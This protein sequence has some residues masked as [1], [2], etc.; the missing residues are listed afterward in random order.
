L[1]TLGK[2]IAPVP[3]SPRPGE[4]ATWTWPICPANRR[5]LAGRSSPLFVRWYVSKRIFRPTDDEP[6][7]SPLTLSAICARG[8]RIVTVL[9]CG[10]GLQLT[11][12]MR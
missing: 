2:L 9:A 4:S 10:Q 5:M 7:G 3:G 11:P 1:I 6:T 12:L 8:E